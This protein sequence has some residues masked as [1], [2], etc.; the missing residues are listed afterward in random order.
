MI[1]LYNRNI[2]FN[3][4]S[5]EYLPHNQTQGVHVRLLISTE[6]APINASVKDLWSHVPLGPLVGVW[7]DLLYAGLSGQVLAD[8]QSK[9][10]Q[11]ASHVSLD[12]YVLG[13]EVAMGYAWFGLIVGSDLSVEVTETADDGGEEA[14]CLRGRE[15]VVSEIVVQG[16]ILVVLQDHPKLCVA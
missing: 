1:P 5:L 8:G 14:Q 15:G 10:R 6:A 9:I 12:Q 11:A 2:T 16:A 13:L 4:A 7:W 3:L